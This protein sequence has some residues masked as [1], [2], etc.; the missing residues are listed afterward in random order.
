MQEEVTTVVQAAGQATATPTVTVAAGP[1]TEALRVPIPSSVQEIAGLRARRSELADQL[2]R[3]WNRREAISDQ[4]T[5]ATSAERPGLE[6]R[7]AAAD[8]RVLQIEADIAATER[9]LTATSPA[10]LGAASQAEDAARAA[11]E[12]AEP[13][14]DE[15]LIGVLA[16]MAMVMMIPIVLAHARRIWKRSA[17]PRALTPAAEG[18]IE[19]IEQAVDAIAV[20][21][22]RVSE[23]QRF[24]TKLMSEGKVASADQGHMLPDARYRAT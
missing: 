1:S 5:E 13:P 10:L 16:V 20:E 9:A 21:V 6:A 22:E 4:M 24:V 23:G 15:D 3:A 2:E 14:I 18:R 17:A 11:R 19:R 7:M 8:Q 12:A